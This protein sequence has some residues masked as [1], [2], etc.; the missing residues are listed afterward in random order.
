MSGSPHFPKE[1]PVGDD[2]PR[3]LEEDRQQPVFGRG[4]VTS[5]EITLAE[6]RCETRLGGLLKH[7]YRKAA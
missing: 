2:L 1:L 6:I 3:T 5:E 7:Y 4:Q